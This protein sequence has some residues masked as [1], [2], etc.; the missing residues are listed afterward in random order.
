[1]RW[2]MVAFLV[3]LGALLLAV[4][5]IAR[6]VWLRSRQRQRSRQDDHPMVDETDLEPGP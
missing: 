1:M 6:H 3:S 4:A 5:G 2:L